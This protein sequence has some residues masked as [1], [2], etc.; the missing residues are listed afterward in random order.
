MTLEEIKKLKRNILT[1]YDI[2]PLLGC[3]PVNIRAQAENDINSFGFPACKVKSRV[4]FPRQAFIDW[5][6]TSG[7]QDKHR[8]CVCNAFENRLRPIVM[9]ENN[10]YCMKHYAQITKDG[11]ITDASPAKRCETNYYEEFNDYIKVTV[12][13]F[14]GIEKGS[15]FIDADDIFKCKK[16]KWDINEGKNGYKTVVSNSSDKRIILHRYLLDYDGDLQIDHIDRNPLNNRKCNL[17]IVTSVENNANKTAKNLE[18]YKNGKYKCMFI[19]YGVQF[20]LG[21]FNTQEEANIAKRNKLL[22][23]EENKDLYIKQYNE[24]TKEKSTGI[25]RK[26]SGKWRAYCS[27]NGKIK[28][29]GTYT[30]AEE[31]GEARK[32]FLETCNNSGNNR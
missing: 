15:F 17:R 22:E 25:S 4:K 28:T 10:Y 16:Y 2:A 3:D 27:L 6:E 7:L 20:Y 32:K 31:A 23:I 18:L 13:S 26:P 12:C 24:M 11:T 30:T 29:I 21:Y 1:P 9:F 19:R 8:C 5:L 14:S